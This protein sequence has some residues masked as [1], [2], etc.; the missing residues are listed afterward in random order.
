MRS[1]PTWPRRFRLL[2]ADLH[3]SARYYR[4]YQAV[5]KLDL[6]ALSIYAALKEELAFADGEILDL[7]CGI[8]YVTNFIG[9]LGVDR[10]PEAIALAKRKFPKTK[11]LVSSFGAMVAKKRRFKAL[12]CVNVLEHLEDD[13]RE[14][15]FRAVPKL[16]KP[17]G[18]VCIVYDNM[19]HPLQLLSGLLHPG[20]LL[21][22]P[23]HVYCWTPG[24][25]RTLLEGRLKLLKVRPGNILSRFLP[26]TNG[27]ASAHL[28]VCEPNRPK[29]RSRPQGPASRSQTR[30]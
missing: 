13:A 23:T 22:D 16:L 14:A 26:W 21:T 12:V 3:T 25:F 7:G 2:F 6:S 5:E 20:M 28:Y 17:K 10:N 30:V 11:F 15:F 19:Y 8:G 9:G 18:R 29:K 1:N 24:R 27:A 4:N